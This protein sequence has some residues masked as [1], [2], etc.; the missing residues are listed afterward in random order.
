[1]RTSIDILDKPRKVRGELAEL[2]F[3]YRAASEGIAVAKPYGDSRPYDFLVQ[4]GSRISRVQVKSTFAGPRANTHG[5]HVGVARIK[6]DHSSVAYSRQEIDII[7]AFIAPLDVW[8]L[9]P[10][11]KLGNRRCVRFYPQG[12]PRSYGGFF[13]DYLEA[14]HLLKDRDEVLKRDNLCAVGCTDCSQ[15]ETSDPIRPA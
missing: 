5:F 6:P 1:M 3:M 11:E 14:W 2:A 9:V 10:V 13:E 12:S 7:A 8:Y 4:H 15:N